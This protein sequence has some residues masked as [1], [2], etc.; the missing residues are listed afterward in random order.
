MD[1]QEG[2]PPLKLPFNATD[3]PWVAAQAFIH[4]HELS[5]AFL[6]QV[7][8]FIVENTKGVTLGG[9]LPYTDPFTGLLVCLCGWAWFHAGNVLHNN[10][11]G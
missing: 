2:A 7:A 10:K 1:I 4:R 6:D 9:G 8:N 5:Q 11:I 3:D